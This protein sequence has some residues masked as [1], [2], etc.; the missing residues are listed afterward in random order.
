MR[1]KFGVL[2]QAQG[3]HWHVKFHPNAFIVSASGAKNHNFGQIL[4]F[5]KLLYRSPFTDEAKFGVLDQTQ[6]LHL[7]VKFHLNMFIVSA[8]GRRWPKTTIFGKL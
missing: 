8:S 2:H 6:G 5:W 4:T 3:L 7:Q 1:V